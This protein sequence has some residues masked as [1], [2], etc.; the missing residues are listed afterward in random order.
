MDNKT[1]SKIFLALILSLSVV[2]G[3]SGQFN[4]IGALPLDTEQGV[5]PLGMGGAFV[6][7]ADDNNAALYNPGGLAWAKGLSMHL[8]DLENIT[9][10]QA[11]PTGFGSSFGLGVIFSKISGIPIAGGTANTSG[12][13]ILVSYGTKLNFLPALYKEEIFQ[14]IGVG[15][16]LKALLGETMQQTGQT[17]RSATG[18]DMDLGVLWKG[19]DWWNLGLTIQNLLPAKT[20]NGGEIK[21]DVGGE[22]DVPTAYKLGGSAKLIGDIGSPIYADNRELIVAGELDSST[23]YST[24]LKF[25]AEIG[26]NKK[27]FLRGGINQQHNLTGTIASFAFGG[28][29]RSEEWGADLASYREP[30][31][32][33][34][35]IGF[36]FSYFPK[37]WI[38]IK[39]LDVDRPKILLEQAIESISLSDN[40]ICYSDTLEVTGRVKPGVDVYVNGYRAAVADDQ[41]F[42]VTIPLILG[43]NLVVVEARFEG[44]KKIWKYK[45]LRQAKV[46][47]PIEPAKKKNVEELVTLGVIDVSKQKEFKL[48]ASVTRGEIATWI[49][50]AADLRLPAVT[51]D[52]FNDVKQDDPVA[53]YAQAV[54]EW[55]IMKAY[56]DGTFRPNSPV[57]R[58]EG[59]K[60]FK[61][62]RAGN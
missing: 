15:F 13:T 1:I 20:L 58:E 38:V 44:D 26:F 35:V 31:R 46:D 33:E 10:I 3:A 47:L 50:K 52:P 24:L 8:R 22:E 6:G 53:P 39:R 4:Q 40:I 30:L 37:D 54:V 49:V 18:W 29:V 7:L 14:R 55:G 51:K 17:D 5:R 32:N 28:G 36:S 11:Y 42:K 43:K 19:G 59:N 21:W 48:E 16:N 45:V 9:A 12:S 60:L 2:T 34:Q 27:Y 56:P 23:F 57:S 62:L 25:G 61:M 41:S